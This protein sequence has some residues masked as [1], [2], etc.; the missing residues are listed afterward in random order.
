MENSLVSVGS[1][2]KGLEIG[3]DVEV[4]VEVAVGVNHW[5]LI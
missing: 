5:M 2:S 3:G 1:W 4:V